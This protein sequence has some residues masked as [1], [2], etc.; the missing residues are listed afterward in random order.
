MSEYSDA[1]IQHLDKLQDN[2]GAMAALRHSLAFSPGAYFPAYPFVERFVPKEAHAR[3][4]T[5]LSLYVVASL[6][7][8][9][10]KKGSLSLAS[11]LGALMHARKSD[12]IEKR[13]ISLLGADPES[14]PN[15]LRQCVSLMAA[16]GQALNYSPLLEDIAV[17]MNP[18]VNPEWRDGIRQRWARDFYR[19]IQQSAES[20]SADASSDQ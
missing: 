6:F 12:S 19:A 3:D 16:D 10:P 2:L 17:W 5:R 13:F 15:Y 18:H 11:G 14:L 9:H 4:A 8:L 7:A 1:F 20:N